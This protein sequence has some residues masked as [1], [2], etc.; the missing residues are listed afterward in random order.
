[1]IVFFTSVKPYFKNILNS[2]KLPLGS[3]FYTPF[4]EKTYNSEKV[5][6]EK[7]FLLK[8]DTFFSKFE[9]MLWN[10]VINREGFV[11]FSFFIISNIMV[12]TFFQE[13]WWFI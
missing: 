11:L 3:I 2:I 4:R 12:K 9:I 8:W 7:V 13:Y 6:E 1:M 5:L 10:G